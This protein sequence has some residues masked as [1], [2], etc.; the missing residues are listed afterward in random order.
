LISSPTSNKEYRHPQII[1]PQQQRPGD[2]QLADLN[3]SGDLLKGDVQ[4]A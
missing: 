4:I 1:H 3:R 2:R